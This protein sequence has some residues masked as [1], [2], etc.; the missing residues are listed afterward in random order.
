MSAQ[1]EWHRWLFLGIRYQATAAEH[2]LVEG[3]LDR[4]SEHLQ[5]LRENATRLDIRKYAATAGRLAAEIAAA[6]GDLATAEGELVAGTEL[7]RD[8]PA[9]LAAWKLWAALG[10]VRARHNDTAGARE[11]WRQSA[12]IIDM[13]AGNVAEEDLRAKFLGSDAVAQVRRALS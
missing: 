9:P 8:R 6:R 4:A 10:S 1:D 11:A 5:T 12:A 13:I 7:L 2:F 3:D